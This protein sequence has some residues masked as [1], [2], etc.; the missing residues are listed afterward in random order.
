MFCLF[1]GR[2]G[3]GKS[4]ELTAHHILPALASGRMVVTNLPINIPVLLQVY[5]EYKDLI[6]VLPWKAG[7]PQR[8]SEIEDYLH[9]WR[10]EDTNQGPLIVIDEAHKA[11]P[12][13]KT[14]QELLEFL[15]ESRHEGLDIYIATQG[16][17][18]VHADVIDLIDITYKFV[19]ARAAGSQKRYI[20]KVIDGVRG[21]VMNTDIRDYESQYFRFYQS[22]TKSNKA[23]LESLSGDVKPIWKHWTFQGAA[24]CMLGVVVMFF[25]GN[26]NIIVKQ[27][28]NIE[29]AQKV[30]RDIHSELTIT[31]E[32][33]SE[34]EIF[35]IDT[36]ESPLEVSSVSMAPVPQPEPVPEPDNHPYYKV[37][38]HF[39]ALIYKDDKS[40][41]LVTASQ[42]GQSVFN[43]TNDDLIHAGYEVDVISS[44]SLKLSYPD[45]GYEDY[46]TC[47]TPTQNVSR[48]F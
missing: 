6:K 12:K 22:H 24:V 29:N 4:Y 40:L 3:A 30:K 48:S 18:K 31:H 27:K 41:V 46:L 42:N 13:G 28:D 7:T 11:L 35:M 8:F 44:C 26:F 2:T 15:A 47:T 38:L 19:K 33:E 9:E 43:I 36:D 5:P 16:T 10:H 14:N 37:E 23:V 20:R 25:N 17:R 39:S 32:P 21:S 45:T 1:L 34:P